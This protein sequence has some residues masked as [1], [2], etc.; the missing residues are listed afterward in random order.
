MSK[1][2]I[3]NHPLVQHKLSHMRKEETPSLGFRRLLK[4]LSWLLAYEATKSLATKK[5]TVETPLCKA[6]VPFLKEKHPAIVSILRAGNGLL[7]GF[8]EIMPCSKVGFIGLQREEKAKKIIEYYCK[9]P[10]DLTKREVFVLD[11]MLA[12][13]KSGAVALDRVKEHKPMKITFVCL[14]ASQEGVNFLQ[15]QHPDVEIFTAAVDQELNEQAYIV[16]G[17]GDAGDRIYG[18]N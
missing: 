5:K 14:L 1:V 8:L 7:D 12:T 2:H 10:H 17:L 15:N 16:P 18:T 3:V 13:G 11:P 9:L 6:S 4:E